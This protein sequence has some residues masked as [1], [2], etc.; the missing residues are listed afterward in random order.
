MPKRILFVC[1]GNICRSPTADGVARALAAQAGKSGAFEFDSAGTE[2][3][4]VGEPPDRRAQ[5][6]AS[7]RGYDLSALRARRVAKKDF[8]HFDLILAMDRDHLRHLER[9][10]PLHHLPKL[11]LFL[12]YADELGEM[13]VPDPYYGDDADFE[14]VLD[15]C[16]VVIPRL[17]SA[18]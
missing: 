10:C 16:E 3:Y 6:S 1:T 11:Q 5:R 14:V 7:R 15:M 12:S 18:G 2:S 8:E 4:H 9:T 17:L 13:D